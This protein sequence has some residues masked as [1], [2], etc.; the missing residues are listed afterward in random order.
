MTGQSMAELL[1]AMVRA[2]DELAPYWSEDFAPDEVRDWLE[3]RRAELEDPDRLEDYAR[4]CLEELELGDDD[5]D[6]PL[7]V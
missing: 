1:E 3:L 5:E 6:A 4:R 2:L 7:F